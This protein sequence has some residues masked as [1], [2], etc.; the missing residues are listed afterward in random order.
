MFHLVGYFEDVATGAGLVQIDAAVDEVLTRRNNNFYLNRDYD[1]IAAIGLGADLQR[2]QLQAPSFQGI[3]NPYVR[4]F[5]DAETPPSNPQF[6]DYTANPLRVRM[7]D[8][9]RV[10]MEHD[11]VGTVGQIAF[12]ALQERRE[13]VPQGDVFTLRGTATTTL[14]INTWST[15]TVTW[16]DTLPSGRYAI[17]GGVVQSATGQAFRLIIPGMNLRPGGA[18]I[19]DLG[20]VGWPVQR[21]GRMGLWG[22]FDN[23]TM[24][25]VQVFATTA[26]TAQ[27]IYLDI[28]RL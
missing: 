1:I 2:F 3:L 16:D 15:L 5:E 17:I 25:E 14:T 26:D 19:T 23:S 20:N 8:E 22:M 24:P 11:N 13:P 6:A 7:G 27:Q 12:L 10:N 4:P 9:L 21:W 18:C 28:I